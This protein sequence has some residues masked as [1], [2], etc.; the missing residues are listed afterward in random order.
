M[1]KKHDKS[2]KSDTAVMPWEL[3]RYRNW[4]AVARVNRSVRRQLADAVAS[5]NIDLARFDILAT[6]YRD[7]GL[8]QTELAERLLAGRSS[9][10]MLLPELEK[11]ELVKRTIDPDDRRVRRVNLTSTF[12][13]Q[14]AA[15]P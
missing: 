4:L 10:T 11:R 15:E 9:L 2:S 8:A 5:L 6:L 13:M 14:D 7:P 3:P 12:A 1:N